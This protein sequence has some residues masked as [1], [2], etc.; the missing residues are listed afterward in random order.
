MILIHEDNVCGMHLKLFTC[1]PEK[2][3]IV[4]HLHFEL[5]IHVGTYKEEFEGIV[6]V[7]PGDT[8]EVV[9]QKITDLCID[10]NLAFAKGMLDNGNAILQ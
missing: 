5:S 1:G 3:S 7:S 9:Y 4:D 8:Q 6:Y 2:F 10:Q